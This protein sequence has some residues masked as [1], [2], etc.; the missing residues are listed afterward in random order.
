MPTRQAQIPCTNAC[1]ICIFGQTD[2][3]IHEHIHV[4]MHYLRIMCVLALPRHNDAHTYSPHTYIHTHTYGTTYIRK[5]T[6]TRGQ[7]SGCALCAHAERHLDPHSYIQHTWMD[8]R[9]IL[10]HTHT[11]MQARGQPAGCAGFHRARATGGPGGSRS[12]RHA[13][14]LVKRHR[15]ER[16]GH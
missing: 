5:R 7:T 4:Y 15:H 6:H 8:Y 9:H 10:T 13:A 2:A 16:G 1:H 11:W 3:C 12:R 14:P